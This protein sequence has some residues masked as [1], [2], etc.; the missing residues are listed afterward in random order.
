VLRNFAHG[1]LTVG[2]FGL[3][4]SF[5]S[6]GR[7]GGGGAFFLVAGVALLIVGAVLL[8][9]ASRTTRITPVEHGDPPSPTPAT[10]SPVPREFLG[11]RLGYA[12][13]ALTIAVAIVLTVYVIVQGID[14][15]ILFL[16][17]I[18]FGGFA[19]IF[20]ARR[21]AERSARRDGTE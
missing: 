2:L 3:V 19:I 17:W 10:T 6:L 16:I 13:L 9:I 1:T 8:I 21:H 7:E 12:A 11:G 20:L 4:L 5:R 14:G 18:G 15:S